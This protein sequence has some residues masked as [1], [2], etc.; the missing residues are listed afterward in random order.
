MPCKKCQG[1]TI[2]LDTV[3][4]GQWPVVIDKCLNCSLTVERARTIPP[5]LGASRLHQVGWR[6]PAKTTEA[7]A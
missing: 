2:T 4:D 3:L 7:E 5:P 1:L 6:G